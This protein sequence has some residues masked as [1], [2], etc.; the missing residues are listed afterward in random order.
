MKEK[1]DEGKKEEASNS[2]KMAKLTDLPN[3]ETNE[4]ERETI[5]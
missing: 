1:K 5:D 2:H 4:R 3:R